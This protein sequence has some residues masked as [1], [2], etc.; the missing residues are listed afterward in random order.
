MSETITEEKVEEKICE[1][2]EEKIV[3]KSE[4][5]FEENAENCNGLSEEELRIGT[6]GDGVFGAVVGK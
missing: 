2:S 5:K 1:K 4:E 6:S 3:E